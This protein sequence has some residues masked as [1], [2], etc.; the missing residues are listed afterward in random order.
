MRGAP[1]LLP[2]PLLALPLLALPLLALLLPGCPRPVPETVLETEPIYITYLRTGGEGR[3]TDLDTGEVLREAEARFRAGDFA[4]AARLYGLVAENATDPVLRRDAAHNAGLC[5]L[6][7]DD[8]ALAAERFD[9]ALAGTD[10][11]AGETHALRGQCLARLG[12]WSEAS[13]DFRRALAAETL[14]GAMRAEV[15]VWDA[16]GALV[17]RDWHRGELRLAEAQGILFDTVRIRE[18]QG[19]ELLAQSFFHRGEIF[20]AL[21]REVPM[22]LPQERMERDLAARR[23]LFRQAEDHYSLA[24]RV[25][26]PEWSVRAGLSLGLMAEE[27]AGDLQASE[28]PSDFSPEERVVYFRE[29]DPYVRAILGEAKD[30]YERTLALAGRMGF[31]NPWVDRCRERLDALGPRLREKP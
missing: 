17:A 26:H 29:L 25:R 23:A 22:V 18:Q 27:F 10:A 11:E 19:H 14:S 16:R 24:I 4:A 30:Y 9:R 13:E 3:V 1:L 20:R 2:L 8:L 5:A 7:L 6:S 31:E 21:A 15:L 28:I 12:R